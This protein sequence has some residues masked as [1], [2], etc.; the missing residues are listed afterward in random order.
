MEIQRHCS[1]ESSVDYLPDMFLAHKGVFATLY[2]VS[3]SLCSADV[4]PSCQW[5]PESGKACH[6]C[7][8][9]KV[10]SSVIVTIPIYPKLLQLVGRDAL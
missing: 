6:S 9:V 4:P 2:S 3:L 7:L 10:C 1:R 5:N 8:P